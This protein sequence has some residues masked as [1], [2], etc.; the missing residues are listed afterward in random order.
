MLLIFLMAAVIGITLYMEIPRIAFETQRQ[1]EQL[2][3]ARGE[4][5]KRAIQ[6]FMKANNRWPSK[7]EELESLNNKRYLRKRF[8]DPMTGKDEW[9][10][11]HINNG[12]LTD[13]HTTKKKDDGKGASTAGQYVGEQVGL[14]AQQQTQN[15]AANGMAVAMRKRDSDNRAPGSGDAGST[16]N[17]GQPVNPA[18]GQPYPGQL[19]PGGMPNTGQFGATGPTGA[20]MPPLPPGVTQMPGGSM[21]GRFG[22]PQGM[23]GI[24]GQ[25]GGATASNTNQGNSYVGSSGSY[26]GGG[27]YIGSQPNAPTATGQNQYPGNPVN[28][29]TGGIAAAYGTTPGAQGM[30]PGNF[31]Q[32]GMQMAQ[33]GQG[34][35]QG[36]AAAQMIQQILTQP[37]PGGMPATNPG[38][39]GAMGGGIAGF[40][41]TADSDSIMVY[42]DQSNYGDWEFVF[43]PSK[44]KPL[45][46]P[47]SGSIGQSAAS[48]GSMPGGT[49]GTPV[50]QMNGQQGPTPAGMNGGFG[51]GQPMGG[52]GGQ[53]APRR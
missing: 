9:R 10:V 52:F 26:V 38:M 5:Y 32:P 48:M 45:F 4:Q 2:L 41:S 31:Q 51:A 49:P 20:G 33:Q 14:V 36:N 3:V 29:Q 21:P 11:I 30:S 6:L 12:V 43:D 24:S 28:S 1:K 22:N 7:I 13:S 8:I 16:G 42:N 34:Q 23:Q 35:A 40:A 17:F 50:Q 27:S 47:N 25:T 37:R 53:P 18:T 44:V 39:Q 19:P 15:A 46:N